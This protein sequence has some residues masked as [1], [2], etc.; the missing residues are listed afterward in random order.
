MTPS[1]RR[2]RRQH[3]LVAIVL[4]TTVVG[5]CGG[6]GSGSGGGGGVVSTSTATETARGQAVAEEN[7]CLSCHSTD[8][9]RRV[10]P[11]WQ[12][13]WGSTVPLEDGRTAEVDVNYIVRSVREPDADRVAGYALHMPRLDLATGDILAIA[14]YIKSLGKL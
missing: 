6:S 4:G 8:G 14:D 3:W 5:G 9:S 1:V 13:I 7:G 2:H 11:T 12:G 10:G